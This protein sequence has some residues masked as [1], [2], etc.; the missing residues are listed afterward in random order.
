MISQLAMLL[1]A[2]LDGTAPALTTPSPIVVSTTAIPVAPVTDPPN[3][4]PV[5]DGAWC[6]ACKTADLVDR[7]ATN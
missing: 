4:Q 6:V 5:H 1:S 2:A 3:I 7:A